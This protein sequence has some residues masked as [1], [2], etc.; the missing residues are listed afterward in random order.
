MERIVKLEIAEMPASRRDVKSST[1]KTTKLMAGASLGIAPVIDSRLGTIKTGTD[2]KE[3]E[4]LFPGENY[5]DFFKGFIVR[6]STEG[7]LLD[8]STPLHKI[9]YNLMKVHPWVCLDAKNYNPGKHRVILSDEEAKAEA[10]VKVAD[11][12]RKAYVAVDEMTPTD[13]RKFLYLYG[14]DTTKGSDMVVRDKVLELAEK[15]PEKFTKLY[16]DENKA[17]RTLLKTLQA[18]GIVRKNGAAFFYGDPESSVSLGANE[19]LAITFLD[20]AK[21]QELKIRLMN[22]L[23]EQAEHV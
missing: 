20:D 8:L 10:R 4:E 13:M 14:I 1:G 21:N 22:E 3:F 12:R 19:E 11:M 6:L 2:R 17:T 16:Y 23:E 7:K 5:D 9:I 15:D 18:R